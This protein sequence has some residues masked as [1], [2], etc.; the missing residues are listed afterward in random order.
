MNHGSKILILKTSKTM[1]ENMKQESGPNPEKSERNRL[2]EEHRQLDAEF[3][4]IESKIDSFFRKP[5]QGSEDES[6]ISGLLERRKKIIDELE[7]IEQTL[8]DLDAK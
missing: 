6:E 4:V 7:K 8:L 2:V 3:D 5:Y 1:T